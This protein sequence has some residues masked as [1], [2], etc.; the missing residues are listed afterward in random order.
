MTLARNRVGAADQA[1]TAGRPDAAD[2]PSSTAG[3]DESTGRPGTT[4]RPDESTGRPGTGGRAGTT[5]RADRP[6]LALAKPRRTTTSRAI[7]GVAACGLVLVLAVA[8]SLCLGAR[9]LGLSAVWHAL[10][11]GNDGSAAAHIVWDLRIPRTAIGL[12][13]GLALGVAGMVIQGVTRNPLGDPGLLGIN[14][15]ASL[16]VVVALWLGLAP[17]PL[18]SVWIAFPGAALAAVVVFA[19]GHG[20]PVRLALAGAA[21]TALITPLITLILLRDSEVF[22]SFRFWSVGSLTGRDASA[23]ATLWPFVAVG[24]VV[25]A[26]LAPRLNVL[27]LGDDVATALGQGVP[28]TRA[29]SAFAI[30]VLAGTATCLAGPLALVGLAAPHLGRLLVRT[31]HRWLLPA[32]AFIGA[33]MVLVADT[34]GRLIAPPG[35]IEAGIVVAALGAPVLI[36]VARSRRM[37]AL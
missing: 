36:A 28:V 14:S 23:V 13:A 4:D 34:V 6:G 17:S 33:A 12:L 10:L 31:D 27:A 8:L 22:A 15:G 25:A 24:L 7:L 5:D 26:A 3:P 20:S 29:W 35:E 19:V 2:R 16:A 37:V 21:L 9:D 1:G 18:A 30:V 32:S 11:A